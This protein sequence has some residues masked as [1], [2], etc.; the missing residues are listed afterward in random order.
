MTLLSMKSTHAPA[1][2][3]RLLAAVPE[4]DA[5]RAA[6][7]LR[8]LEIDAALVKRAGA[9]AV[10]DRAEAL[11]RRAGSDH[12]CA[13]RAELVL[14]A[15]RALEGNELE[16]LKSLERA[17]ASGARGARAEARAAALWI[18]LASRGARPS[19][20]PEA[21]A[22]LSRA[23]A[24]VGGLVAEAVAGRAAEFAA[25]L[26]SG[27]ESEACRNRLAALEPLASPG[28]P[29]RDAMLLAM[30]CGRADDAVR[31]GERAADD[32]RETRW[33]LAEALLRRG[34]EGDEARA[35]ELL[36]ALSPM[37]AAERDPIWWTAQCLQLEI[38]ARR[39]GRATDVV[40]RLNRLGALDPGLGGKSIRRRLDTVRSS[41]EDAIKERAR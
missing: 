4:D 14:A 5:T 16:S 21:L 18:E 20:A 28:I 1:R 24:E 13:G 11:A 31:A 7:E 6:R 30:A 41:A 36:R 40:S 29:D 2:A 33:L 39:P 15:M 9:G 35:F 8:A 25:A 34:S 37:Q 22:A 23:N 19:T 3:A 27:A 17:L 26:Q 38:L 12:E 10:A 32:D